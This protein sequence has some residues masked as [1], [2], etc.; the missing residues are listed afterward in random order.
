[1]NVYEHNGFKV[2]AIPY[3]VPNRKKIID[4]LLDLS[5]VFRGDVKTMGE[6]SEFLN[7]TDSSAKFSV[8]PGIQISTNHSGDAKDSD[9]FFG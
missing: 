4:A 5:K 8:G 2:Y 9:S 3:V 6:W 7:K 1:M